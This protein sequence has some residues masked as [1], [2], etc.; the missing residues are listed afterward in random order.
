[1]VTTRKALDLAKHERRDRRDAR[2]THGQSEMDDEAS[3]FSGLIRSAEPEPHFAAE[4]T[5]QCRHL[6]AGL[7]DEQLRQIALLK[8]EGYTSREI[9]KQLDLALATID[10]RLARIRQIWSGARE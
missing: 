8:L 5:E 3:I 6:L 2:R 9:A 7:P 4:V 1:M 10:R